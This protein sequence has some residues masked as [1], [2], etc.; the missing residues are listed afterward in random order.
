M[1]IKKFISASLFYV[2]NFA[3]AISLAQISQPFDQIIAESLS[4]FKINMATIF[5]R[6]IIRNVS[7]N[8][9]VLQ[10]VVSTL[11]CTQPTQSLAITR[12][13]NETLLVQSLIFTDCN[14]N[15]SVLSITQPAADAV[16]LTFKDW[17]NGNWKLS[18]MKTWRIQLSHKKLFMQKRNIERDGKNWLQVQI[19]YSDVADQ[20]IPTDTARLNFE[21]FK[22]DSSVERNYYIDIGKGAFS[23][24]NFRYQNSHN[25][26]TGV[27]D[28][29]SQSLYFDD[30]GELTAKAFATQYQTYLANV[31][32]K[33]LHSALGTIPLVLPSL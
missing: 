3:S 12:Q 16:E 20:D 8:H 26:S 27:K 17:V 31:V 25:T 14:N 13:K 7:A 33:S 19:D 22:T 10:N 2:I 5:D 29:F 4:K 15:R 6:S 30:T 11:T 18:E 23:T 21:E 9:V 32:F 24:I 28:I 1:Q